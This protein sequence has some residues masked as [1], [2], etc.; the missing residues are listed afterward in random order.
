[1]HPWQLPSTGPNLKHTSKLIYY[2]IF[3]FWGAHCKVS[4]K[5]GYRV[6]ERFQLPSSY[7]FC[8]NSYLLLSTGVHWAPPQSPGKEGPGSVLHPCLWSYMKETACLPTMNT[9]G[10]RTEGR[11]KNNTRVHLTGHGL[12]EARFAEGKMQA[13]GLMEE[14]GNSTCWYLGD[15]G[16][17]LWQMLRVP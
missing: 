6:N 10:E 9:V 4:T 1:M 14:T 13:I 12:E 7:R 11:V 2:A 16:T 5:E 3:Q 17:A 15:R 8:Y